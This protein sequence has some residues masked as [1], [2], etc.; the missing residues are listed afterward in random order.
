MTRGIFRSGLAALAGLICLADPAHALEVG[1]RAPVLR[2]TGLDGGAIDLTALRG[3]V[4]LVNF[5]ASWCPPCRAEMPAI[6]E[7]YRRVHEQ[8]LE[9]IGVSTDRLEAREQV[10]EAAAGIAY[11]LALLADGGESGFGRPGSLP[12]TYVID[13]HGIIRARLDGSGEVDQR[14]LDAIVLPLLGSASP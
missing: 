5:W 8:G 3:R 13:G 9:V 12:V 7:L 10:A 2:L 6:D 11:P 1:D 14:T 4:V